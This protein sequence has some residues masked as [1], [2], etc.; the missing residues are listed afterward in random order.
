MTLNIMSP[1][2]IVCHGYSSTPE[3]RLFVRFFL[4]AGVQP[5]LDPSAETI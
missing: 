5:T 3:Y 4:R 2:V 1:S